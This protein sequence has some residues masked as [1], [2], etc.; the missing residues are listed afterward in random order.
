MPSLQSKF[1][2]SYGFVSI[3]VFISKEISS[4]HSLH[5]VRKGWNSSQL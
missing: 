5:F 2:A 3:S 4:S 1:L